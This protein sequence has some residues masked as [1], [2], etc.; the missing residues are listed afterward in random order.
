M[1]TFSLPFSSNLHSITYVYNVHCLCWVPF[2]YSGQRAIYLE[3]IV[4]EGG[5]AVLSPGSIF[6]F[7]N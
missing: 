1:L 5:R 6:Q 4:G 2:P 7:T 3:K